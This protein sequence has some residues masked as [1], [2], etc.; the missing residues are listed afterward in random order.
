MHFKFKMYFISIPLVFGFQSIFFYNNLYIWFQ[1][2]DVLKDHWNMLIPALKCSQ[3]VFI[4]C[5]SGSIVNSVS[6]CFQLCLSAG[7]GCSCTG[8]HCGG[9]YGDRNSTRCSNVNSGLTINQESTHTCLKLPWPHVPHSCPRQTDLPVSG[10]FK[11]RKIWHLRDLWVSQHPS[12]S[13]QT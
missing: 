12:L 2:F 3:A 11:Q 7:W 10:L 13:L 9:R 8:Q 4:I 6:V 1:L 5:G